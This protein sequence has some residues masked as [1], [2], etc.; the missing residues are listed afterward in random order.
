[1]KEI[2]TAVLALQNEESKQSNG[3][4]RHRRNEA[5]TER[6]Q[7][8]QAFF[9]LNTNATRSKVSLSLLRIGKISL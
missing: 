7:V 2:Q 8:A 9:C 1:M 5:D 6:L 3:D 4:W